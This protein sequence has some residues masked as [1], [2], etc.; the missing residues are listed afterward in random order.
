[1]IKSTNYITIQG[2]MCNELNLKGNELLIYALIYGFSQDGESTFSGSRRYIAET[3]N[4]SLPTVDKVIKNLLSAELIEQI[5][6]EQNGVIFNQYKVSLHPIKKLYTPCK[7]TLHN[8]DSNTKKDNSIIIN[9]NTTEFLGSVTNKKSKSKKP[10]LYEKCVN[11]INEFTTD[12]QVRELLMEY[13]RFLIDLNKERGSVLYANVFKGKLNKL[14]DFDK[15]DWKDIIKQ[16][17]DNG[18]QGFF[19]LKSNSTG[20]FNDTQNMKNYYA[21]SEYIAEQEEWLREVDGKTQF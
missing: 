12:T 4:I 8:I 2:W 17:L 7:E 15:N 6:V 20:K 9:N 10:N 19:E 1:M 16:T 5:K 21:D 11:T 13:L 3:F 18:W 14:K